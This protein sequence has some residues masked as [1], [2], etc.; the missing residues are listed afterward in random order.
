MTDSLKI[1]NFFL[2]ACIVIAGT[3]ASS[4]SDSSSSKSAKEKHKAE[5]AL[6]RFSLVSRDAARH[7]IKMVFQRGQEEGRSFVVKWPGSETLSGEAHNFATFV[8]KKW[9]LDDA[10][11]WFL[12]NDPMV[13]ALQR[14][15]KT[16]PERISNNENEGA[17]DDVKEAFGYSMAVPPTLSRSIRDVPSGPFPLM[18]T[19]GLGDGDSESEWGEGSPWHGA[20]GHVLF[21]NGKVVWYESTRNENN[22]QGVFKKFRPRGDEGEDS[23]VS[24]I[25]DAIPIG[26]TILSP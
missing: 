1:K 15:G 9:E 13:D 19:R 24:D 22:P 21:S 25:G 8:S 17:L 26:W 16:L 10:S 7:S 5:R 2:C 12:P 3:V 6:K 4:C 23:Y 14:N 11:I 20:G 18:W